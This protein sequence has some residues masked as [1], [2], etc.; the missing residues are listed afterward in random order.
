MSLPAKSRLAVARLVPKSLSGQL[1][2]LVLLALVIGEAA[3]L[4]VFVTERRVALEGAN[5]AQIVA[6]VVTLV[7]LLAETPAD[8]HGRMI[9]TA[10]SSDIRL[11][12]A[13]QSA[14]DVTNQAHRR[15]PLPAAMRD[16]LAAAGVRDILVDRTAAGEFLERR[17]DRFGPG[18][19][20]GRPPPGGAFRDRRPPPFG[21]LALT[22]AVQLADGSWLNAATREP[23]TQGWALA[24]FV[25]L[26]ITALALIGAVVLMVRRL[27]RPMAELAVA[28]DRMGRGEDVPALAMRGPEDIR[29]TTEA[30]NRMQERLQRFVR[31]RT[32]M[33]AAISHDLRSPITVLRLRAE[34][35]EDR[36]TQEKILQTLAE[37]EEMCEAALAFMREEGSREETRP[38]DMTTLVE[39]VC[40]DLTDGGARIS[41]HGVPGFILPGRATGLRRALRNLIENAVTYGDEATVTLAR[42]GA[43]LTVTIEDRG[44]GIAEA[45]AER[46]FAPFYRLE[47][48]RNR[49]TGG[50]GLG[51][52]IARDIV[53]AHG[54]DIVLE[55]LGENIGGPDGKTRGLRVVVTLP[56]AA[57]SLS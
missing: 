2:V 12:I 31:D 26:G 5:R 32:H 3:S 6:R 1:I 14:V 17:F 29:R 34:L 21:P 30:F 45:E 20:G 50:V 24:F 49:A 54:G 16:R 36:E 57:P 44:P 13:G 52:S 33:L 47:A 8:L 11:W 15:G 41:F 51:L 53:R 38:L 22:V 56:E 9:L 43:T 10:N 42:A 46:V 37:M 55:N 48:S 35:I 28:A 27:T 19:P 4:V 23:E 18:G 39:A 7:R 40:A 25:S